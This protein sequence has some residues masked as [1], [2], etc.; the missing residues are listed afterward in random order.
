[1]P[2]VTDFTSLQTWIGQVLNRDDLT[3]DIPNFIQDG[4]ARL[5]RDPRARLL[6]DF[7]GLQASAATSPLPSDFDGMN[8]ITEVGPD[9][10]GPLQEVPLSD[11]GLFFFRHGQTGRPV[12]YA[13]RTDVAGNASIVWAPAP[14]TSVTFQASYWAK[15]TPLS[16]TNPTNRLLLAHPDIYRYAALVESAPYLK[17][18]PRLATWKTELDE[19]LNAL[20]D[21]T[22]R[23]LF[24]G[25]LS[26]QS[27]LVF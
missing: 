6:V 8:E 10:F 4:E 14:T 20:A 19:R 24:G 5:A 26:R 3:A 2:L 22:E 7:G 13:I 27:K 25:V 17:D 15:L 23:Q 11:L 21:Q 1:M 9:R 16:T 12:A 18:D